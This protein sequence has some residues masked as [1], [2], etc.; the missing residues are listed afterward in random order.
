MA[1][2]K[3]TL[4]VRK[5]HSEVVYLE[6]TPAN[7]VTH[8]R[9]GSE[10]F[11]VPPAWGLADVYQY[12][13]GRHLWRVGVN[14]HLTSGDILRSTTVHLNTWLMQYALAAPGHALGTAIHDVPEE[15]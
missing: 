6:V 11:P 2:H 15:E 4:P 13:R 5:R 8:M 3:G 1:P 7:H 9:I 12:I 10:M 14:Q